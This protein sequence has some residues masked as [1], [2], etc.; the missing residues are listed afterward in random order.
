MPE[1]LEAQQT[2]YKDE[3]F[4]SEEQNEIVNALLEHSDIYKSERKFASSKHKQLPRIFEDYLVLFHQIWHDIESHLESINGLFNKIIIIPDA[5]L[6]HVMYPLLSDK[7]GTHLLHKHVI[8]LALSISTLKTN[9][10][11]TRIDFRDETIALVIG[12]PDG[13][14]PMA[15]QESHIVRDLLVAQSLGMSVEHLTGR[16][17]TKQA[18][19]SSLPKVRIF[20]IASHATDSAAT[21]TQL[22]GSFLLTRYQLTDE[23]SGIIRAEEIQSLD[24]RGLKLAFLNC[25]LTGEGHLYSEGLIGLARAFIY[26]GAHNVIV[27][28]RPVSDTQTTCDFA[29]KFYE[30]YLNTG[31]ADVAL[32]EAQKHMGQRG[33]DVREWGSYYVVRQMLSD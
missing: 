28:M 2:Y 3:K 18:I 13:T 30:V 33:I 26:A 17:A 32:N 31:E 10:I 16:T 15:T 5:D 29:Q 6:W 21:A 1:S 11:S 22:P 7:T 14:L 9:A 25:C 4:A 19:L 20:H 24:L 12:N 8:S 27:S 23:E